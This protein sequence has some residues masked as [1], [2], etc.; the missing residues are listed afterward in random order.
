MRRLRQDS[1]RSLFFGLLE[2][3]WGVAGGVGP[4]L[5]GTFAQFVSWRW[6]FWINLPFSVSDLSTSAYVPISRTLRVLRYISAV[7]AP[8]TYFVLPGLN[9]QKE[10]LTT[11]FLIGSCIHTAVTVP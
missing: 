6:I 10:M 8:K 5:G 2:C 7:S 3:I 1:L 9:P 11:T 4:V